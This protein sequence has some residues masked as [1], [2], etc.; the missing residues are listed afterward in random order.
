VRNCF[1]VLGDSTIDFFCHYP[2]SPAY[3][4]GTSQLHIR[5]T[6]PRLC[7]TWIDFQSSLLSVFAAPENQKTD[8]ELLPAFDVCLVRFWKFR[9]G[10]DVYG[11]V[12][13]G[14]RVAAMAMASA[15]SIDGKNIFKC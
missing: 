3:C 15:I 14:D 10:F 1:R 4:A 11:P 12:P 7:V 9:V 2:A 8:R 5:K 13:V 6:N